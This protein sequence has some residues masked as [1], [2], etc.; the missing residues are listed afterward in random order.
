MA[1][2]V[3]TQCFLNSIRLQSW[4]E[5]SQYQVKL[6][7]KAYIQ[8]A[9]WCQSIIHWPS[10]T[11]LQLVL[12]WSVLSGFVDKNIHMIHNKVCQLLQYFHCYIWQSN[13][14]FGVVNLLH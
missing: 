5:G 14:T 9:S 12:F 10:F 7:N 3:I 4:A 13:E 2:S 1:Q 8:L 11:V 6:D